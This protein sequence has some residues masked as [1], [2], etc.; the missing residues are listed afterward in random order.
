[1]PGLHSTF[2]KDAKGFSGSVAS[3][4]LMKSEVNRLVNVHDNPCTR[5]I[6]SKPQPVFPK[7]EGRTLGSDSPL[8]IISQ[9]TK[10]QS[11]KSPGLPRCVIITAG[12]SNENAAFETMKLEVN[13]SDDTQHPLY[14]A[15]T[16]FE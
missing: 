2:S 5:T 14:I 15:R 1:V 10:K 9:D 16:P 12:D 11:S 4:S 6:A 13:R 3:N 7:I 8:W